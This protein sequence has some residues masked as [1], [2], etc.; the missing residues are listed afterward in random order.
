MMVRNVFEN[1]KDW[2]GMPKDRP[3]SRERARLK[4]REKEYLV[5][6]EDVFMYLVRLNSAAH[7]YNYSRCNI[8]LI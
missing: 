6:T 8:K 4:S 5:L 1:I 2:K 7:V 3:K